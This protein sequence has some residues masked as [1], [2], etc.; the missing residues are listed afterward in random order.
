MT[1]SKKWLPY[2]LD[3]FLFSSFCDRE[4]LFR[5]GYKEEILQHVPYVDNLLKLFVK[6]LTL[7]D[8]SVP[9]VKHHFC[10]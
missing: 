9:C 5:A 7:E 1:L 2:A 10:R 3:F 4:A 6:S 8:L